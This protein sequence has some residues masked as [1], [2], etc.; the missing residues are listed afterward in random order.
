MTGLDLLGTGDYLFPN[1]VPNLPTTPPHSMTAAAAGFP[2]SLGDRTR[3]GDM[4]PRFGFAWRMFGSDKTVLRG[5]F[6]IF[7]SYTTIDQEVLLSSGPPYVNGG[8]NS[9]DPLVPSI[10]LADPFAP[11]VPSA[12][13]G[14][15]VIVND[16]HTPYME[17]YSMGIERELSPTWG[18]EVNYVGNAARK[19]PYSYQFNQPVPGPGA[20]TPRLSYPQYASGNLT[21]AVT[22]AIADYSALQATIRRKAKGLW[23]LGSYTWANSL[24]E[25]NAGPVWGGGENVRDYR[26]WKADYGP[27]PFDLRQ[28]FSLGWVADLPFGKGRR[29][30]GNIGSLT[31]GFLGGWEFS[32]ITS[33][34]TGD[35]G[36]VS[37][38]NNT[39]NSGNSRPDI[40]SNPNGLSHSSR[41]AGLQEWFNTAA[42]QRAPLFTFGNEGVGTVQGPGFFDMDLA[43]YKNFNL[44]ALREGMKLQFR[45]ESYNTPN[46]PNFGD[47][48]NTY[49]AG[50]F[51]VIG[52]TTGIARQIQFGLRLDF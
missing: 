1:V 38:L 51:G 13:S 20:V 2:N 42:F 18:V 10:S 22:W 44:S 14:G 52:S 28:S 48:G 8:S 39:S 4:E 27:L 46:R 26:N 41:A 15:N 25:A 37:D 7:H 6:G 43:L 30:A 45:A 47:P 17:Q 11:I 34:H 33:A 12:P 3:Y 32:G 40:I 49:G 19:V 23:L 5:G 9:S 35:Y 29:F 21:A 24:G 16:N 50:N 36:T 31:D